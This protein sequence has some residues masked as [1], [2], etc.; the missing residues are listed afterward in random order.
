M[1]R[2]VLFALLATALPLAVAAPASAQNPSVRIFS[3]D[4]TPLDKVML[5]QP[6]RVVV[7][8]PEGQ[9]PGGETIE[10]TLSGEEGEETITLQWDGESAGA[11]NGVYVYE[12][13]E[14]VSL[15]GESWNL[16][17]DGTLDL[18]FDNFEEGGRTVVVTPQDGLVGTAAI[19]VYGDDVQL[20]IGMSEDALNALSN[21]I[22]TEILIAREA[23]ANPEF[24]DPEARA[25]VEAWIERLEAQRELI[26]YARG[27]IAELERPRDIY[28]YYEMYIRMLTQRMPDGTIM[29]AE[30]PPPRWQEIYRRENTLNDALDER[31]TDQFFD[32]LTGY[33]MGVYSEFAHFTMVAPIRSLITWA[34]TG[35]ALDEFD[36]E[37]DPTWALVEI[38][39]GIVAVKLPPKLVDFLAD[40]AKLSRVEVSL[41]RFRN[42]PRTRVE[43]G[44]REGPAQREVE[45]WRG[46]EAP[47]TSDRAY[48][49]G[50]LD[51]LRE[52]IR[53]AEEAGV[54]AERVREITEGARE[55]RNVTQAERQVRHEL[56]IEIANAGDNTIA[57]HPN[58]RGDFDAWRGGAEPNSTVD[59]DLVMVERVKA[60]ALQEARHRQD[61]DRYRP[62]E[63]TEEEVAFARERLL[64]EDLDRWLAFDEDEGG[65][66]RLFDERSLTEVRDAFA[67]GGPPPERVVADAPARPAD[68]DGPPAEPRRDL[69]DSGEETLVE[70]RNRTER[71]DE[72]EAM[73]EFR[74][75]ET[76]IDEAEFDSNVETRVDRPPREPA[77]RT[78]AFGDAAD[79]PDS[80]TF[81]SRTETLDG[82]PEAR[83]VPVEADPAAVADQRL[84][85]KVVE[86]NELFEY[87]EGMGGDTSRRV[88]K[89]TDEELARLEELARDPESFQGVLEL[90]IAQR[91][92]IRN[93]AHRLGLVETPAG[94]RR[95][96]RIE[97]NDDDV[98][99][100]ALDEA[101]GEEV[102]WQPGELER[103]R[104]LNEDPSRFDGLVDDAMTAEEIDA[105]RAVAADRALDQPP[106]FD[107][108]ILIKARLEADNGVGTVDWTPEQLARARDLAA[109]PS[110]YSG[111]SG[112]LAPAD[113]ET[114]ARAGREPRA[115]ADDLAAG[116]DGI[117]PTPQPGDPY[118]PPTPQ[119]GQ[120][121]VVPP[122]PQPRPAEDIPPTPQPRPR[123]GDAP[124][125][126]DGPAP[127]GPPAG[128]VAIEGPSGAPSG[129]GTGV[130][131]GE[132]FRRVIPGI[133][134]RFGETNGEDEEEP[135]TVDLADLPFGV[136]NVPFVLD[137][138]RDPRFQLVI[139]EIPA[140]TVG[141]SG[142]SPPPTPGGGSPDPD[143][144]VRIHVTS[145]GGL[146]AGAIRVHWVPSSPDPVVVEPGA[147]VLEPV[148]PPHVTPEAALEGPVDAADAYCLEMNREPPPAGAVFR[149]A[150][151]EIQE[152]YRD[153]RGVLDA[154]RRLR[155]AGLLNPDSDPAEYFQSIRQW[156]L[157]SLEEELDPPAF[158]RAFVEETRK[159]VIE[160]G[161]EWTESIESAVRDLVPNRWRD[162]TR[163]LEEARRIA[164]AAA[165]EV[166]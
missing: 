162:V 115:P 123:T 75:A 120:P 11:R 69:G 42:A 154:A 153:A 118:V 103:V 107:D 144:T 97:V 45:Y 76:R 137:A 79:G 54:P 165:G 10:V 73:D 56:T 136:V 6:F 159:N 50:K 3:P 77:E 23:L 28:E 87:V 148:R 130:V 161:G 78:D 9:D 66:V 15:G 104:E 26:V 91:R 122:T 83:G 1:R 36:R 108:Q 93:E 150:A 7:E 146:G 145:A 31:R 106:G 135:S 71:L 157:W 164:G 100:R 44:P 51:D 68:V 48:V 86:E 57:V 84:V 60:K 55:S 96:P 112:D 152:R 30:G 110:R 133:R 98:V 85:R 53:T 125:A 2:V 160:G 41:P 90:N 34:A 65:L 139:G 117:P 140:R 46:R 88:P 49:E 126:G 151:R 38:G 61:P 124:P 35:K 99:A 158:L 58:H 127:D 24:T 101:R 52:S 141:P 92:A 111:F 62:P 156:A 134:F 39:V 67:D 105:V 72:G 155:D 147:V 82:R 63:W 102:E 27:R 121:D 43:V 143:P 95:R 14:P 149:V 19:D 18:D 40:G 81:G 94:G 132:P 119:P 8:V 4:G 116:P 64:D 129:G 166:R 89:Y 13:E 70:S 74:N 113:V 25:E 33:V 80:G 37:I 109:D 5:G 59:L 131:P 21:Q 20:G 12:T 163:I 22:S 47:R 32:V 29:L 142:G 138:P 114:L 16:D 17:V 128:D